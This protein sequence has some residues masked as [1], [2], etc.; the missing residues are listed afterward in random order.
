VDGIEVCPKRKMVDKLAR[1]KIK[2]G[3]QEVDGMTALAYSRSRHANK[4]SD[5][6]RVGQQREV[7]SAIGHKVLSP[8]TVVNPFRY[9]SVNM[10]A[11]RSVRVSD[12]TGPIDMARFGWGL[13]HVDGDN[14]LTCS[15]PVANFAVDWDRERS[16]KLFEYIREDDTE[17]IPKSLCTPTGLPKSTT[18]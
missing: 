14:G 1:L 4:Y 2:K 6:G 11:A 17:G 7:V 3:C 10:A 16:E 12:G 13:M 9:W 8:W 15:V 18:G 5:L